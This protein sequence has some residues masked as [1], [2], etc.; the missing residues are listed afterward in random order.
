M[1][2]A[3]SDTSNDD[4]FFSRALAFLGAI[5]P[6]LT[7]MRDEKGIPLDFEKI[8][9]A[10]ELSNVVLLATKKQLK[11]T[12]SATGTSETL[13]FPDMPAALVQTLRSYLGQIG[14]FDFD[15]PLKDQR[16][17]QVTEQHSYVAMRLTDGFLSAW[18]APGTFSRCGPATSKRSRRR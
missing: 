12:D 11:F 9:D 5:A 6:V 18:L 1:L 14:G 10:T 13:E 16:N 4:P 17:Q 2:Q 8:C 7:W 15:V 3:T